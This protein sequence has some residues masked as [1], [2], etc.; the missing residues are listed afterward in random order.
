M[1]IHTYNFFLIFLNVTVSQ[2]ML[3]VQ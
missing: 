1:Y 3:T 2:P